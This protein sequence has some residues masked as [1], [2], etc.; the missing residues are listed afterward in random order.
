MAHMNAVATTAAIYK[1]LT[2]D[3]EIR[4]LELLPGTEEVSYGM[5]VAAGLTAT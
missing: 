3:K 5:A 1:K 2:Q 4:L